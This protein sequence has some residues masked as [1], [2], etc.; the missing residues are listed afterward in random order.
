MNRLLLT[1]SPAALALSFATPLAA[2]SAVGHASRIGACDPRV[3]VCGLPPGGGALHYINTSGSF[4]LSCNILVGPGQSGVAIGPN[5][6]SVVLDGDG[7]S[8][9]G[10]PSHSSVSGIVWPSAPAARRALVVG[11][12]TLDDFSDAGISVSNVQS[13][14][15][16]HDRHSNAL[17]GM[18]FT[19]CGSVQVEGVSTIQ[20]GTGIDSSSVDSLEVSG[21]V[22]IG[23][24][25]AAS[26]C[27]HS[28]RFKD[29]VVQGGSDGIVWDDSCFGPGSMQPFALQCSDV[30]V[31]D[32]LQTG[33]V[34]N[35]TAARSRWIEELARIQVRGSGLDGISINI[36]GAHELFIS[37]S[38]SS[39][40]GG[41]GL[42]VTNPSPGHVVLIGHDCSTN[43]N[44]GHGVEI[45]S[46]G[47]VAM[48]VIGGSSSHNGGDGVDANV[49]QKIEMVFK[50]VK[51]ESN[52][53]GGGTVFG[54]GVE[55]QASDSSFS[56]NGARGLQVS[57]GAGG[58]GGGGGASVML[59]SSILRG[60]GTDGCDLDFTSSLSGGEVS[61]SDILF[62]S[63]TGH[64]L[65]LH[66]ASATLRAGE[67]SS[68]GS[69]GLQ[70]QLSDIK[71]NLLTCQSNG[72]DG[73][74]LADS[75][76][77]L[78]DCSSLGNS[79]HGLNA[80]DVTTTPTWTV[81]SQDSRFSGNGGLGIRA[82]GSCHVRIDD[83]V[84][85]ENI[86]GGLLCSSSGNLQKQI[87]VQKCA[88]DSNGGTACEIQYARGGLVEQCVVSNSPTGI[89]VGDSSG[90]GHCT[91]LRVSNNVVSSCNTGLQVLT[92][93]SHVVVRN[94]VSNS[95]AAYSVGTGNMFGPLVT[96]ANIATD[97]SPHA[98]YAP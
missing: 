27:G 28:S 40:N 87:S 63:N 1:I 45:G 53:G 17:Y 41:H 79:G 72:G 62:T 60:N 64:G 3:D 78:V 44:G 56:H 16:R 92:G 82:V 21:C 59:T 42:K 11:D 86:V 88:L 5:A 54:G 29:V 98:N 69:H 33:F 12:M 6:S 81:S 19:D 96:S 7:Y 18:R 91:G 70:G 23:N 35:G 95:L 67:C 57:G 61:L 30:R 20:C 9:L 48:S 49:V 22:L 73:F 74:S 71:C 89:H 47:D 65:A 97:T 15:V 4:R 38:S 25:T 8:I 39:N 24:A 52:A 46:V 85:A 2:Q 37:D 43:H 10:D 93:G 76:A 77:D 68:N 94:T 32:V 26:V 80:I 58:P 14:R 31:E 13:V 50:E 34:V 51:I 84:I 36:A 90:G 83:S 55:V 66:N 75:S